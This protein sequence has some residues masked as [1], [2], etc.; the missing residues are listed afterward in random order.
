MQYNYKTHLS[1]PCITAVAAGGQQTYTARSCL[2]REET[3]FP[4]SKRHKMDALS[5]SSWPQPCQQT[6][7][8]TEAVLNTSQ[9]FWSRKDSPLWDRNKKDELPA[10]ISWK[11][12]PLARP[13]AGGI[14]SKIFHVPTYFKRKY[15]ASSPPS[16]SLLEKCQSCYCFLSSQ[17]AKLVWKAQMSLFTP[18]FVWLHGHVLEQWAGLLCLLWCLLSQLALGKATCGYGQFTPPRGV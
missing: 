6:G 12:E 15:S 7:H 11:T 16:L 17:R 3:P 5:H 8:G 14:I 10:A 4:F 1:T 2:L 13:W 9:M 18:N